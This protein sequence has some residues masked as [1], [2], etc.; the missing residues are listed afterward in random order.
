MTMSRDTR[1]F[2]ILGTAVLVAALAAVVPIVHLFAT[3]QAS[4]AQSAR[5]LALYDAELHQ[6][7]ELELQ[8]ASL[9]QREASAA[10]LLTGASEPLAAARMQSLVKAVIERNG[11]QVRSVQNLPSTTVDGLEA[12]EL[13]YELSLPMESVKNTLYQLETGS[14]YLFLDQADLKV[15]ETLQSESAPATPQAVQ[16]TWI[17]RG[18]RW[19]GSR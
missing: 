15:W 10:G 6:R 3:Q 19:V 14:P 5:L 7:P 16:A 17:V 13:Q 12:I 8:L 2:A 11:G 18:Y 1:T 4:I 9:K